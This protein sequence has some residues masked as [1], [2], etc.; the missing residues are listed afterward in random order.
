VRPGLGRFDP[1]LT[2]DF[3]EASMC[4]RE[5]VDIV[6]VTGTSRSTFDSDREQLSGSR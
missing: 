1:E 5:M 4:D 6:E 3:C 2:S